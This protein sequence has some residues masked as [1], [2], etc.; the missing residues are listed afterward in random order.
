M[1]YVSARQNTMPPAQVIPHVHFRAWNSGKSSQL[2][3]R[4]PDICS[5]V[6]LLVTPNPEGYSD[7][8]WYE[9]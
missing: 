3:Q 4:L 7:P 5:G 8:F 1:L 2:S 9:V 6:S